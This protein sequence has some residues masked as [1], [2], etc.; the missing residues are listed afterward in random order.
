ML[1]RGIGIAGL[2]LALIFGILQYFLPQLPRWAS[3]TG[4]LV[5]IFLLGLS[6]GLIVSSRRADKAKAAATAHLRLHVFS[7][8]RLPDR[9][10]SENIFRWYFLKSAMVVVSPVGKQHVASI[11]TLFITFD[12]EVQISTLQVR[13]PDIQLPTHEVKEFNQ[14]FAIIVFSGD[15]PEGTLEISVIS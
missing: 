8:N 9:L 12:P 2:A 5:G 14:R 7:D 3:V 10:A 15:I 6:I 11:S 1:D 13:S 4:I